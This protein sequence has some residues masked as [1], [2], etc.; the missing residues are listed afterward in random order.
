VSAPLVSV[1]VPAHARPERLERLL[2]ALREQTIGSDLFEVIVVADGA[3]PA[4]LDLLERAASGRG[5]SLTVVPQAPARGPGAARNTGWRLAT[6]PLVAF[7]DD[8]CVPTPGWLTAGLAAAGPRRIVQGITLPDPG[9]TGGLV[10][11]SVRVESLGPQYETCNIFYPRAALEP[12]GGF[13]ERYGLT[14]GGEDTD[15]A[16]RAIEAGY[17]TRLAP[18]ALVH[19]AVERLGVLGMLRVAARWTAPMRALAD[20]PP[21]RSMLYR[22]AFWNVWHYLMWRSLLAWLAPR[23]LRQAVF[24]LHLV[25]LRHRARDAGSGGWAV[26]F[27]LVH[28][29]VECWAVARGAL[30]YRT[31]VL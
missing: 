19:H 12:L 29:L 31:L 13:D 15:L 20:H 23:W 11:R 4:V 8:D 9:E 24:T 25:Q 10:S 6:A 17:E 3:N 27:L 14:P 30:R 18:D 7:T 2:S 21:A 1:V 16:W 22:G 28:D 5:L 26:P